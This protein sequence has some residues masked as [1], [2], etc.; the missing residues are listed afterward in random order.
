MKTYVRVSITIDVA[1]C[2]RA[3]VWLVELLVML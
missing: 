1:K 3:V 2:L